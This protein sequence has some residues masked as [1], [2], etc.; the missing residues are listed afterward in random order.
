MSGYSGGGVRIDAG[1]TARDHLIDVLASVSTAVQARAIVDALDVY[2]EEGPGREVMTF[3]DLT[4]NY[5][6]EIEKLRTERDIAL[7]CAQQA[8]RKMQDTLDLLRAD[9]SKVVP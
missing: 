1:G 6:G 8:L 3:E 9:P 4:P 7:D 5:R 2:L